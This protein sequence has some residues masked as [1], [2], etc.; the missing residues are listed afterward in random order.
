[1]ICGIV[2]WFVSN[3]KFLDRV[4]IDAPGKGKTVLARKDENWQR[5]P[6][7]M[8]RRIPPRRDTWSRQCKTSK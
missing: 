8:P 2:T 6:A 5:Q 1:M 4:T 7:T 3:T